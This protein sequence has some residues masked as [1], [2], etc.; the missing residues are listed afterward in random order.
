MPVLGGQ[1]SVVFTGPADEGTGL[2]TG[3]PAGEN[4]VIVIELVD[5]TLEGEAQVA[6]EVTAR[7]IT[8]PF[9]SDVT[10]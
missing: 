5:C 2:N 4:T 10:V 6:L 7:E 9:G 3:C 1:R 8:D